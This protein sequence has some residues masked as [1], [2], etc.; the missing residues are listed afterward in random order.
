MKTGRFLLGIITAMFGTQAF[1]FWLDATGGKLF[2]LGVVWLV[3]YV[4][5]LCLFATC[6]KEKK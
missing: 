5:S 3:L 2:W 4:I 6:E 1:L